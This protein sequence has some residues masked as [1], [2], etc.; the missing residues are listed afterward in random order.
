MGIPA[1]PTL[2]PGEATGLIPVAGEAL[3][4]FPRYLGLQ[5]SL[6]NGCPRWG[7]PAVESSQISAE[8]SLLCSG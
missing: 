6:P 8:L 5:L 1:I 3:L 2:R 7:A 4:P